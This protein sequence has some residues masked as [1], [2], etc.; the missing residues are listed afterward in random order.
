MLPRPAV[1]SPGK[2]VHRGASNSV[3]VSQVCG[4]LMLGCL[5]WVT[6]PLVTA[7]VSSVT[8]GEKSGLFPGPLRGMK[9]RELSEG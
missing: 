7:T 8:W 1:G 6:Q 5:G 4:P 2:T 3:R 9:V